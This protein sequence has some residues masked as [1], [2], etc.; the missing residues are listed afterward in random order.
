[1]AKKNEEL[2]AVETMTDEEVAEAVENAADEEV[3]EN[4]A[5][6]SDDYLEELVEIMLFKDSD[7]YSD[8]LVVT[9]NGKNYQIKRGIK[10]MVPRKVQLVI[11]DSMKQAG[12][13]A[14]YEE[15]AQQ[16]YKELENRL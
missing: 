10:V 6:V 4:T 16:Q 13:A 7:K 5:T 12:L 2:E 15:E 1:M 11:E 14:D 3:T 8:D 9:L